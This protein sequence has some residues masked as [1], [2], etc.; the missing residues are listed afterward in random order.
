MTYPP[1][2]PD[3]LK[4]LAHLKSKIINKIDKMVIMINILIHILFWALEF[5]SILFVNGAI[6]FLQLSHLQDFKSIPIFIRL[7]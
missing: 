4:S 7:V 6:P 1:I 2:P 3:L 5:V